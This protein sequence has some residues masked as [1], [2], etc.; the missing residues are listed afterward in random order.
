MRR[1][2]DNPPVLIV[3]AQNPW[4]TARAVDESLRRV[5]P[6][7]R[8][9]ISIVREGLDAYLGDKRMLASLAAPIALLALLLSGSASSASPPSS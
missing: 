6:S 3:R 1:T 8:P 5:D 9:T 2:L 4:L 7:K